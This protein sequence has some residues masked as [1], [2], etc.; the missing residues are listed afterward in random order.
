MPNMVPRLQ[1][2]LAGL[3]LFALGST[4]FRRGEAGD[5]D[6]D[7]AGLCPPESVDMRRRPPPVALAPWDRGEA[8]VSTR[9]A[10]PS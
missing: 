8:P 10:T 2:E 7:R 1:L 6:L 4:P 3:R 9:D 5:P